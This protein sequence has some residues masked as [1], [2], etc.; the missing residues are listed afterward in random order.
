MEAFS[1]LFGHF[2][3]KFQE[4]FEKLLNFQNFKFFISQNVRNFI[5][6]VN[7]NPIKYLGGPFFGDKTN[8]FENLYS[9]RLGS[10]WLGSARFGSVNNT[11]S[12]RLGKLGIYLA[13]S[14]TVFI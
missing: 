2:L 1:K 9:V 12:A 10:V 4:F 7:K 6:F 14:S 5:L 8:I 13:R 11:E 3:A